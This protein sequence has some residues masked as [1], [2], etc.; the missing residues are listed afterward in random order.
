FQRSKTGKG[1]IIEVNMFDA[2]LMMMSPLLANA[3]TSGKTDTRTGNVQTEK[4]GYAIFRCAEDD[5]MIGAFT[6]G[7]H[8]KLFAA[9]V[10]HELVE[11]PAKLSATWLSSHGEQLRQAIESRLAAKSAS[12]WEILLNQH[13]VPAARV[14]D[15][16]E[17]LVS[18]QLL[19][20]PSSQHRRI[21]SS[22]L[23]APIAAFRFAEDGPKLDSRCA[24]QGEDTD[25][26]LTELGY[27]RDQLDMMKQQGI[28]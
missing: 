5:I 8:A 4:P 12:D 25:A 13:D 15:L 24:R 11:L 7:Q 26:V 10:I 17:M 18:D 22:P 16:H 6:T 2:A 20:A 1:Q 14:R 19:R 3:I 21:E 27:T 23:T 9:L 28:I